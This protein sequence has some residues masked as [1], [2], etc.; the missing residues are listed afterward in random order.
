MPE[1]HFELN[2]QTMSVVEEIGQHMPGGFYICRDDNPCW[3]STAAR[4]WTSFGS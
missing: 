2:E 1:K 4:P 3:I